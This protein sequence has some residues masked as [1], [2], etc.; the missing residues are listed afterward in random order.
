MI[1]QSA[2]LIVRFAK[3]GRLRTKKTRDTC[4]IRRISVHIHTKIITLISPHFSPVQLNAL[5]FSTAHLHSRSHTVC[6]NSQSQ[7]HSSSSSSRSH[8]PHQHRPK[9][10]SDSPSP[11]SSSHPLHPLDSPSHPP[12]PSPSRTKRWY[13]TSSSPRHPTALPAL[14]PPSEK[15]SNSKECEAP[16]RS[17]SRSELLGRWA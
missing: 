1:W 6:I 2:D 7:P 9:N 14:P 11:N 15:R 16:C 17:A 5:Q 12:S 8:S 10:P 3:R 13:C 4:S